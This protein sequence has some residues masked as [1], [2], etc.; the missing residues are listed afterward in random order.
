MENL[1]VLCKQATRPISESARPLR[2]LLHVEDQPILDY[3]WTMGKSFDLW[4]IAN[5]FTP[6]LLLRPLIFSLTPPLHPSTSYQ[7]N[8][9][10]RADEDYKRKE[11]GMKTTS[12]MFWTN[13]KSSYVVCLPWLE[14]YGPAT[15]KSGEENNCL[16]F[17]LLHIL[18]LDRLLG[19]P[20]SLSRICWEAPP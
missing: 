6:P 15:I 12:K 11:R 13:N 4:F 18:I 3:V 5:R 1:F 2:L 19:I 16:L 9:S 17:I 10:R 8:V 7:T 20:K 14:S